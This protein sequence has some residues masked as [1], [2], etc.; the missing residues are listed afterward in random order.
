MRRGKDRHRKLR[1]SVCLTAL[2]LS[3]SSFT[4]R[5][6]P[7]VTGTS[8]LVRVLVPPDFW[9]SFAIWGATGSDRRG[10]L[11]FG[12][13]SNDEKTGSAHL[14]ELD[15]VSSTFSDRGN[16][17]QEL[18]R[19][20]LR[21]PGEIQ[22]KIHSRIVEAPDGFQYFASM[23]ES[24]ENADGS[25]LPTWGGHLWR[26]G[27]GPGWEHLATTRE[28]LIAVAAGGPYV[29]ALGYFNHVLYQFDTRTKA[30]RSVAVGAAGGH[31]S[32]NFFVDARGHAFVPRVTVVA[33]NQLVASLVEFNATL[34]E[35]A[36]QPLAEYFERGLDDS[37]GIVSVHPGGNNRWF[38]TT[39]KGRL[40]QVEPK[41]NGPSAV[42]DLGWFHPAGARYVA[43]MFR[44]DR[45]GTL[46]GAAL[47]SSNGS[48]TADWIVRPLTGVPT[49]APLPYGDKPTFE[50]RVLLYG[51]MSRDSAGRFYVV[52]TS[53]YKPVI[54][55]ITPRVP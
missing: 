7:G 30:V 36:A 33:T 29:Y 54:L 35:V 22:M 20:G 25:R 2:V 11:W 37:H 5:Q 3:V 9:G 24:G 51:S 40:Y 28:A 44:D 55:Q 41:P 6:V 26:R 42:N 38:F 21:R 4:A 50:N 13:T 16:V 49:V 48:T 46:Y 10:H 19:L 53:R 45:T 52:G 15:P 17:V 32:R 1:L 27:K 31:V 18:E 14:Y 47:P 39:G 23:D 34:K 12:M 43:S 8:P